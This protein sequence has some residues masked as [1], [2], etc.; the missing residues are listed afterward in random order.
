MTIA[1]LADDDQWLELTSTTA[2]VHF[3]RIRQAVLPVP[4]AD[5]YL[6]LQPVDSAWLL[7][8]K[9][10]VL[11]NEVIGVL[12]VMGLPQNVIRIN[13]WHGFLQRP[14]WEYAGIP[15]EKLEAVFT[16]LQKKGIPVADEPGLVAA[17]S[18]AMIINEAYYALQDGVSSKTDIDTAM[19]LGTN[20]PY[21][22][23]EWANKIG[24]LPIY[25][26]LLQLSKTDNR[27]TICTALQNEITL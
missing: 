16:A 10:P 13:G 6:V 26:L 18:I 4:I 17:R 11:L 14:V 15:N 25:Q 7:Q 9:Q 20:Y 24:L 3:V 8:L 27:Y 23:F 21:G 2:V 1:V 12:S 5:A 19:K 22:P